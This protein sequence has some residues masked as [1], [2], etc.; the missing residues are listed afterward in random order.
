MKARIEPTTDRI[1]ILEAKT[2]EL[3]ALYRALTSTGR[4]TTEDRHI[5][6]ELARGLLTDADVAA[7]VSTGEPT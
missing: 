4:R 5:M 2:V 1:L 3:V 6:A 7:M